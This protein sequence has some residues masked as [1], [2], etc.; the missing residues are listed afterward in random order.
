MAVD[1][2]SLPLV[3]PEVR[4]PRAPISPAQIA[5]PY[6]ELANTLDKAGE[7]AMRD[8]A[9]PAARQAGLRAVTRDA[10]GDVQVEQMPMFGDAAP[11]FARAVKFAAVADGEGDLKR[12]DI[13]LRQQYRD[14]PDLYAKAAQAYRDTQVDKYTKLAGREVGLTL[15]KIIDSQTTLTYRG[16]LN[17][18]E[19]LTLQ[20]ADH[21][22][23][24]QIKSA[25]DDAVA[26]A[27]GGDTSSGAYKDAVA[28]IQQL[29]DERVNNPRLAYPREQADY[30]LQ[31][32]Q[33]DL[34]ANAF[35]YHIDQVYKNPNGGAQKA[36]DEAKGILADP[37]L[38]LTEAERT[39]YYHKAVGEIHANESLRRADLYEAR[40]AFQEFK[41]ASSL[42]LPIEPERVDALARNFYRLN[43]P[44]SAARLYSWAGKAPLN[45]DF[46]RQPLSVQTEQYRQLGVA[47]RAAQAFSF[48]TGRGYSPEQASAIIGHLVQESQLNPAM[49]H[50]AGIG[51]GIA[52]WNRERLEALRGFAKEKGTA[53]T[54]FQTQLEFIDREL[55]GSEAG[56][57]ARLKGAAS[58]PQAAR[59][60]MDYFRPAGWT[61]QN[62]EAGLGFGQRVA[63]GQQVFG[64]AT[65]QTDSPGAA[66]W[67]ASNRTRQINTEARQSWKFAMKEWD[68]KGIVPNADVVKQ[69]IDAARATGDHQL[70]DQI[71][72]GEGASGHI[73][74]DLDRIDM[75]QASAQGPL[76]GQHAQITELRRRASAGELNIGG[77]ITLK[78][79][80]AKTTAIENGLKD[81]PLS[82]AVANFP[83]RLPTPPPLNLADPAAFQSGMALRAKI[84]Q[85]AEQNWGT[86]PLPA[87]D[88]DDLIAIRGALDHADAPTAARIF[89]GITNAIPDE[90]TR[91][92][93]FGKLA[94]ENPKVAVQSYAGALYAQ[95]PD[96]AGRIILGQ[97]AMLADPRRN[98]PLHELNVDRHKFDAAI[99]KVIPPSAFSLEARSDPK[100]AYVTMR[101]AT[102]ANY[103]GMTA[104]DPSADR[105]FNEARLKQAADEVTGGM[106]TH[107]GSTFIAPTRGMTQGQFDRVLYGLT[108]ADLEGATTLNGRPITADYLR[109]SGGLE[110]RSDGT[111][112]VTL[113]NDPAKPVYAFRAIDRSRRDLDYPL[114]FVLDLRGRKEG[115]VPAPQGGYALVP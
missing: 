4:A 83:D 97:H 64:F 102:I 41:T 61:A 14:N 69:V 114:P 52:G 109:Q 43:D 16:L 104:S 72:G 38:K 86:R 30:D 20:R 74:G 47:P 60:M 13:A 73:P 96:V 95:A 100:G 34:K 88:H 115:P 90:H 42:G 112:R 21:S 54:D 31:H 108:D 46:G 63:Y 94:E 81:N 19:R 55:Q 105:S 68:E 99:D 2:P 98:D 45:D 8:V 6:Q 37:S 111:Y 106:L 49:T 24:A 58:V 70:L 50:D 33:G 15:G 107:N 103:A 110:S 44:A 113:G 32:L 51:L 85:F 92:A 57:G 39:A 80:E 7:V 91:N 89:S 71:G 87:L 66:L 26:M 82:T 25:R 48:F 101:N 76:A 40:T 59:V 78:Q 11:E 9:I 27:R 28:K 10:N 29:T 18:H 12:Q 93:T 23:E 56:V 67:L 35:L 84:A 65:G 17:E 79:L 62:P 1:L 77:A 53:P 75:V 5:S 22:L 36:L 3:T